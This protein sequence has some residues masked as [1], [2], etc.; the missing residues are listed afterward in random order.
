M[1]PWSAARGEEARA[2]GREKRPVRKE[3]GRLAKVD[4]QRRAALR[5]LQTPHPNHPNRAQDGTHMGS[6]PPSGE[7]IGSE[8]D[9][10][11]E[12]TV[13][14][15]NPILDRE[16]SVLSWQP[17]FDSEEDDEEGGSAASEEKD[18]EDPVASPSAAT[19]GREAAS[20]PAFSPSAASPSA[21]SPPAASPSAASQLK[22]GPRDNGANS[23][24]GLAI[25]GGRE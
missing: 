3:E 14:S 20:P 11:A 17:V 21:A 16:N 23:T 25:W 5:R 22:E 9:Y 24:S 15:W 18:D 1:D 7:P 2:L 8:P 6:E 12:K 13:C 10:H 4:R 19:A